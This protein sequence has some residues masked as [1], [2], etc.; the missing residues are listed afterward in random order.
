LLLQ[1]L[2]LSLLP[3]R[4]FG[5]EQHACGWMQAHRRALRAQ[6]LPAA[7]HARQAPASPQLLLVNLC[8]LCSF[9]S[10]VLFGRL[11]PAIMLFC[12]W[13]PVLL[14]TGHAA[15]RALSIV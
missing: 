6:C 5:V 7:T 8:P 15:A 1:L 14:Q 9:L 3:A 4:G 10:L 11:G 13:L 2:L 12:T